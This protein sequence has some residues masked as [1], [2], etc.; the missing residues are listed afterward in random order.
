[1]NLFKFGKFFFGLMTFVLAIFAPQALT[2]L[3]LKT[4]GASKLIG[5]WVHDVLSNII[6]GSAFSAGLAWLG[7]SLKAI[8]TSALRGDRGD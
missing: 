5:T 3:F 2:T 6:C 4:V 7:S 8:I 1:M